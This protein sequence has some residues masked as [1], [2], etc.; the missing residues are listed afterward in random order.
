MSNI[1]FISNIKKKSYM[2]SRDHNQK[3]KEVCN[4]SINYAISRRLT[5]EKDNL[6]RE[7]NA[8][9]E[10]FKEWLSEGY[11]NESIIYLIDRN[12]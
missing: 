9:S 3:V 11:P 2:K 4:A 10:E 7:I 12:E 1:Y 6:L 5:L 8:I